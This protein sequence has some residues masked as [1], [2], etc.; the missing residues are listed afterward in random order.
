MVTVVNT[1]T[2]ESVTKAVKVMAGKTVGLEL[3]DEPVAS[4][5]RA[6][7]AARVSAGVFRIE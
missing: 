7:P 1:K 6:P 4:A 5:R 2:G 3:G